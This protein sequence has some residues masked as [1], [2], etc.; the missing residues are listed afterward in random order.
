MVMDMGYVIG[1]A[2]GGMIAA[3][4]NN[5]GATFSAMGLMLLISLAFI[6]TKR[7]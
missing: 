3:Y 6:A 4:T 5:I 7:T 2:F 1:P